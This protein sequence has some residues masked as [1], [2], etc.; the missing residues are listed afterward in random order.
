MFCSFTLPWYCLG[1]IFGAI[2]VGHNEHQVRFYEY[3]NF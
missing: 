3:E 1:V 2:G